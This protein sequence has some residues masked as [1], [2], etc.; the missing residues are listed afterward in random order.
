[1]DTFNKDQALQILLETAASNPNNRGEALKN[2]LI[3]IRDLL[4]TVAKDTITPEMVN[5]IKDKTGAAL[6]NYAI[7]VKNNAPDAIADKI[8]TAA[9][10]A[11][12]KVADVP[13][14]AMKR[15]LDAVLG[16]QKQRMRLNKA[17]LDSAMISDAYGKAV[18]G[19]VDKIR[20]QLDKKEVTPGQASRLFKQLVMDVESKTKSKKKHKAHIELE[21]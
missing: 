19:Q 12:S 4:K 1:M 10:R 9:E 16:H 3:M 2:Y 13:D 17:V 8:K 11:A 18:A 21:A 14:R 20:Q 15:S 6:L 5:D 7:S